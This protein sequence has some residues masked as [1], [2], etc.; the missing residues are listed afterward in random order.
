MS[1]FFKNFFKNVFC[2]LQKTFIILSFLRIFVKKFF[3]FLKNFWTVYFVEIIEFVFLQDFYKFIIS[4]IFCQE[5]FY[6]FLTFN[7]LK[8]LIVRLLLEKTFIILSSV[9]K[10]VNSFFIFFKNYFNSLFRWSYLYKTVIIL[11]FL[12]SFVKV[13]LNITSLEILYC[14]SSLSEDF[15]YSIIT[16]T[17]CQQNF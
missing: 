9:L 3:I 4:F 8:C 14:S 10:L 12:L 15:Y 6:N 2:L 17:L 7:I 11:A 16:F 13:F 5:L 1:S